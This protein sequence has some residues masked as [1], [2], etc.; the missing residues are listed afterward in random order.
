MNS[1]QEQHEVSAFQSLNKF[2]Q[3]LLLLLSIIYE[4]VSQTFLMNLLGKTQI[5]LSALN[6]T[7]LSKLT[8]TGSSSL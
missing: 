8:E 1:E 5:I 2:E 3:S 6:S 4:P 7:H